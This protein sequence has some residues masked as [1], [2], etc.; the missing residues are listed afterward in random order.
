MRA[1]MLWIG[2]TLW[3]RV[4]MRDGGALGHGVGGRGMLGALGGQVG[5]GVGRWL[6]RADWGEWGVL[7]MRYRFEVETIAAGLGES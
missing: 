6:E 5:E 2:G 3:R 1:E 4:L 7:V